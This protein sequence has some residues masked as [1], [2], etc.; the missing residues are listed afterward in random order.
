MRKKRTELIIETTRV[1]VAGGGS[2]QV[3]TWCERC[4]GEAPMVAVDQ[5]AAVAGVPVATVHQRIEAVAVHCAEPPEGL[6]LVCLNSLL[7]SN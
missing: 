7:R 2:S 1:F 5:A 4:G 3:R 6:L